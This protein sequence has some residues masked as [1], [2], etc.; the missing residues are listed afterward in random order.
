MAAIF[1]HTSFAHARHTSF[2]KSMAPSRLTPMRLWPLTSRI[3]SPSR[4]VPSIA[5][6]EF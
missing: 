6:A 2:K 5:A 4:S 1:R 3:S